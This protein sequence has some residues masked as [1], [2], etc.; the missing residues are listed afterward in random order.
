MLIRLIVSALLF[1]TS[2]SC[3][4]QQ[5]FPS[6]AWKDDYDPIASPDAEPGG[7]ISCF[8]SQYPKSFNY[9][10]DN[11]TLSRSIFLSMYETLLSSHPITL[12][13][14]PRVA[15][16]WSISEDKKT[17]TFHIDPKAKWSDGK[18]I[19]AHDVE[20]T[21]NA[22]LNP[23]NL[24]GPHKI[25]LER[26]EAPKIINERT[27]AFTAKEV[28]WKNLIAVGG[29]LILP[30]HSWKGKEFNKVN[31]EFPVVSGPYAISEVKEG[32]YLRMK[33]R[34]DW[35]NADTKQAEGTNNFETLEFRFYT[36]RD[37]AYE[38]FKKGEFDF[39]AVYTSHRWVK[40]TEG[41]SFDKNWIVKQT[42]YNKQPIGFQGF[43]M[44][45]R[46][47]KFQDIKVRQALA[48]LLNREKMNETLMHN[49]YFLHRSY[50]EDLYDKENP[51][52]NPEIK[53]DKDKA[54]KLLKE[55][56]WKV[57]P[58]TGN[59]E[60]DGKPFTITFLTR[61]ASTDKFL[62]IYKED[63]KDVGI[64]LSIDKKD[65]AAWARD[66]NEFNFEMTWQSWAGGSPKRDPESLWYSKEADR[67]SGNNITGL[68]NA[69]IDALIE[70]QRSIFDFN[71]RN[72]ILR[73]IDQ[74]IYQ[75]TP[76]ILLWNSQYTRL[77]YWNK[78]GTP[79]TVLNKYDG[80]FSAFGY[81]WIDP[82]S[83]ADLADARENGEALPPKEYK[84]VFD[85]LFQ[86]ADPIMDIEKSM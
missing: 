34:D 41:E 18:P 15:E 77:L 83:E 73:E 51:N 27:I 21:F 14:E 75:E 78:F 60:K 33:R 62:V 43:A 57:N 56:G 6:S 81:W 39:F 48:H 76:Y 58:K 47:E 64:Q 17:F 54:R 74:L 53:F 55:A 66:I 71:K 84:I 31:F 11:N 2:T 61:S 45:M 63:L 35:W 67:P 4:A 22:I 3:F 80:E 32:E 30:K 24:T 20:W 37:I 16:R 25:S 10:L 44:N 8:A 65:W 79:D 1:L 50:F 72:E 5:T 68:K 7:K 49:Q 26:F 86:G 69:K 9:Y 85:E 23:K 12:E 38:S 36:Q 42:I 40:Q 46:R 59:L 29:F 19:T 82:D 13:N 52:P 28:H 70:K